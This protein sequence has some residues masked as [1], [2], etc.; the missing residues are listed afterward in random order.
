M[1]TEEDEL[2]HDELVELSAKCE[3][4]LP[5]VHDEEHLRAIWDLMMDHRDPL[6]V[7]KDRTVGTISD[8]F[9]RDKHEVWQALEYLE[10]VG[11]TRVRSVV[12]ESLRHWHRKDPDVE[13]R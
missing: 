2:S 8:Y 3:D 11:S 12:I 7:E 5:V 13:I 1:W 4:Q 6:D 10:S 9:G